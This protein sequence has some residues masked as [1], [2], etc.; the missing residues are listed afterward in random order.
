MTPKQTSECCGN[1]STNLRNTCTQRQYP[2]YT[3]LKESRNGIIWSTVLC[4][5]QWELLQYWKTRFDFQANFFFAEGPTE[6][7]SRGTQTWTNNIVQSGLSHDLAFSGSLPP[8]TKNHPSTETPGD[9][10]HRPT[11]NPQ[12]P[13]R[14]RA[15]KGSFVQDLLCLF[16]CSDPG[17]KLS[18]A[19]LNTSY[20]TKAQQWRIL[21]RSNKR[22]QCL[23]S[24]DIPQRPWDVG[25]LGVV[26]SSSHFVE[27]SHKPMTPNGSA[28]SLNDPKKPTPQGFSG[29]CGLNHLTLRIGALSNALEAPHLE[30]LRGAPLLSVGVVYSCRHLWCQRSL[31]T[32][33]VGQGAGT[34]C[35]RKV[36]IFSV[37]CWEKISSTPAARNRTMLSSFLSGSFAKVIN[38]DN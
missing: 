2:G 1:L 25:F 22:K 5:A 16:R 33:P 26:I 30:H 12:K 35:W 37:T 10:P 17:V 20:L 19:F 27:W 9:N 13:S 21:R 34:R 3:S 29:I 28:D 6:S 36:P 38:L 23:S 7:F 14:F 8:N 4:S 31:N 11:R 32:Q 24:T 18:L 15:Q